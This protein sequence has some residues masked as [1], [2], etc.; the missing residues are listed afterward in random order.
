MVTIQATGRTVLLQ[1]GRTCQRSR[2]LRLMADLVCRQAARLC[3]AL[4]RRTR[5]SP[6]SRPLSLRGG[7]ASS[8]EPEHPRIRFTCPLCAEVL[9][10]KV[11]LIAEFDVSASV[12][13]IAALSGC[14]HA[15]VFGLIDILAPEQ[16]LRLIDAALAA[17]KAWRRE[18]GTTGA[19]AR[20]MRDR[21]VTDTATRRRSD[22][23]S[24]AADGHGSTRPPRGEPRGS[25][26]S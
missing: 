23:R 3:E 10:R 7:V 13:T 24:P 19:G 1:S 12:P 11:P 16:E 5:S 15:A 25:Q 26:P 8:Q 9:G 4:A 14:G 18:R 22:K 2:T 21:V 17:L 6:F 20:P